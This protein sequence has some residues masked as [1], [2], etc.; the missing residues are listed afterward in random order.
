MVGVCGRAL[1]LALLCATTAATG[2]G[3]KPRI[4][5]TADDLLVCSTPKERNPS[6]QL[7]QNRLGTCRRPPLGRRRGD[8]VQGGVHRGW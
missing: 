7:N 3:D 8:C 6:F 1:A 5:S 2:D 4:H